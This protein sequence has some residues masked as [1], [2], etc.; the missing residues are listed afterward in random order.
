MQTQLLPLSGSTVSA[1]FPS[2]AED[3]IEQQLD[4]FDKVIK[5]PASTFLV[6][7]KGDSMIDKG[8]QDGDILVVD[9]SLNPEN[10]STVIAYIDGEFTVKRFVKERNEV[11]L[12]PANS[13]YEPITVTDENDFLVW[14][15]VTYVLHKC[16]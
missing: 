4:I 6:R 8:I 2:P 12:Y 3:F 13:N 7:A 14:G 16:I 5:H 11:I 15:V 1:G 9:K 10:N